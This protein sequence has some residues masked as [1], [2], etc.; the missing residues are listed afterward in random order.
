[1]D[2]NAGKR[3]DVYLELSDICK[4]FGITK[5]INHSDFVVRLGMITGLIGPNGAGKSTMMKIITGVYSQDGGTVKFP[6]LKDGGGK[7][8]TNSARDKGIYCAYQELSL[9]TNLRVYENFLLCTMSHTPFGKRGFRTRAR[10]EAKELLDQVFPG[11]GIHVNSLTSEL[12]MVQRQMVEICKAAAHENLKVLLLDEP[13]S[14]LPTERI[15]QLHSYLK[16]LCADKNIAIIYIS[17]KLDEVEQICETVN[18][19]KN[20]VNTEISDM[21]NV[22]KEKMIQLMGGEESLSHRPEKAVSRAKEEILLEIKDYSGKN[23]HHINLQIR[24]GEIIG[25]SGLD[26]GGQADLLR[27]IYRLVNGRKLP[28][29][30]DMKISYVSGDRGKEGILPYWTIG[31]NMSVASYD[32]IAPKGLV[33]PQKMK[34]FAQHWFDRFSIRAQSVDGEITSLSGGNAQKVLIARGLAT[35]ADIILLNDPTRGVDIGTKQEIYRFMREAKEEKKT[36]L[37]FST[38][39]TE[40]CQCDRVCIMHEGSI[41]RELSGASIN[42]QNIVQTAFEWKSKGDGGA[43]GEES[44]G[45]EKSPAPVR[46]IL[47]NRAFIAIVTFAVLYGIICCMQPAALTP[48][49]ITLLYSSVVPLIFVALGQMFISIGGGIDMGNSMS[50]GLVNVIVATVVSANAGLGAVYLAA[51]IVSYGLMGLLILKTRI[52]AVIVTLGFSFIWEGLAVLVSPTP[53]GICP[54]WLK[55]FCTF[56]VLNI[57]GPIL[58]GAVA[59]LIAWWV[60]RRSKYG[61]VLNALGNNKTVTERSGWSAAAATFTAYVLS[62]GFVVLSGIYMTSVQGSGDYSSTGAFCM[63]SIAV[64]I[65]GGCEFIGAVS[66][67]VGVVIAAFAMTSISTLLTFLKMNTNLQQMVTGLV[68]IVAMFVKNIVYRNNA[69]STE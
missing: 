22:T 53:G 39:D 69:C 60:I 48:L 68:L 59:A 32:I 37:L 9:C 41:V 44:G 10:A 25:I 15:G 58:V 55:K 33:F 2:Q 40:M 64:F 56:S 54:P 7:Y 26:G 47:S 17:H 66:S 51:V 24:K 12:T 31:E 65:L 38:E 43:Q 6:T 23:L 1:M 67:P 49:G 42:E 11:N 29:T 50:V 62:G 13:T 3:M 45:S 14:F 5:A 35:D 28:D 61:I 20:G 34:A 36:I 21:Q 18:V 30:K 8:D 16:K 46:R 19:M 52:P 27:T 4:N 57:P 63:M